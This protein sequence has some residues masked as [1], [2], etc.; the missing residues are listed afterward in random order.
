VS[1][2]L[3]RDLMIA[4]VEPKGAAR[5]DR[6][7]PDSRTAQAQDLLDLAGHIA[8][9]LVPV[10]PTA[11]WRVRLHRELVHEAQRLQGASASRKRGRRRKGVLIGAAA[12]GSLASV[13]GVIVAFVLRGRHG[14]AT[15][16]A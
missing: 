2:R 1:E 12:L 9:I 14:R 15:H 6:V 8:G 3:E 11:A 16:A 13:A 10:Q 4:G 5:D 7:R